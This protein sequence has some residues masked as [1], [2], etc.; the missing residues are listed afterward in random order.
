MSNSVKVVTSNNHAALNRGDSPLLMFWMT[1]LV[2]DMAEVL[3][4]FTSLCKFPDILLLYIDHK[5][6]FYKSVNYG[7]ILS[8]LK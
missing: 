7:I 3:G 1:P 4:L 8:Y 2:P 6:I 5:T